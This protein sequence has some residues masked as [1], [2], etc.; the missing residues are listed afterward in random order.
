M[1]GDGRAN[2]LVTLV[3]ELLGPRL[4]HLDYQS[5]QFLDELPFES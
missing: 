4:E 5:D 3:R 1:V 2:P